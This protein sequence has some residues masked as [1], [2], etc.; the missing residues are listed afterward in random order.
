M[1]VYKFGGTSAGSPERLRALIPLIN[2]GGLKIVVLSAMAGTTSSLA[3]IS[4]L[5]G[6]GDKSGAERMTGQLRSKYHAVI[7]DLFASKEWSKRAHDL[8]DEHFDFI[9]SL[10]SG[11]PARGTDKM[12]LARGELISTALL[13]FLLT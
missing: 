11:E 6:S 1:K 7:S 5:L 9:A 10:I 3:E 2:D 4:G 13:H 12:I 8:A